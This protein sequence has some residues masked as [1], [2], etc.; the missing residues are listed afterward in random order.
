MS[1]LNDVVVLDFCYN[2]PG[3]FTTM[4]LGDFGAEVI[5]VDPPP[6]VFE[7]LDNLETGG[8]VSPERYAAH[9]IVDRNKRSIQLDL[10]SQG[11]RE[12]VHRLAKKA[13]VLVEGYSPGVMA[14]LNADWPT[15]SEINPRLIY[16]SLSGFGADGPYADLPAH[17][18][19]YTGMGGALSLIGPR[20]GPPYLP[21]S[22]IAD[23]AGAGLHGV[24][25][26]LLALAAREKT[27]R[28]QY[29]DVAYF[30]SVISLLAA[31]SSSY[32]L[33]GKVP[34]RGET[35]HTGG[36]PWAN[37]YRCRDG[38]YLT[39]GCA[40]THFWENLCLAIERPDL[41]ARK[42]PPP[43]QLD[44]VVG[45]LAQVFVTRT[46]DEWIAFF[47]HKNVCVGPVNHLDETFADPHVKH[48]EMVVEIEHPELG[49]VRQAGIP[50]KLSD[51]PGEIRS[52]GT[53]SGSEAEEILDELGFSRDEVDSL[54]A[55]RAVG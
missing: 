34:R 55:S 25:G 3:S 22:L 14:R 30:D 45:E 31:E 13:D 41:I 10:K 8:G 7:G 2:R 49:A 40:E 32:F 4:F 47:R 42:D 36:A 5:R 18:W 16:C 26:I 53:P 19:N 1:A 23:M 35:S 9:C 54:R 24:V 52:L 27:G 20:D 6:G 28:G 43:D 15:L 11:G 33:T 44:E 37:V 29:V 17:D 48:R 50:I 51:T 12:V 38:E 39:V 46:R 21:A